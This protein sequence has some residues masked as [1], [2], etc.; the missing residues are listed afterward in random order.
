MLLFHA[1]ISEAH[2]PLYGIQRLGILPLIG[3]LLVRRATAYYLAFLSVNFFFPQKEWRLRGLTKKPKISPS[4]PS[5]P[6]AS[7]TVRLVRLS[8]VK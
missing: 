5:N 4:Q 2:P 8:V 6:I 3:T 7:P 1:L